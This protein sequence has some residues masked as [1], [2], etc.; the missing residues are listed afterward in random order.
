MGVHI[1]ENLE[2]ATSPEVHTA[3]EHLIDAAKPP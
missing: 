1:I 3:I 2:I